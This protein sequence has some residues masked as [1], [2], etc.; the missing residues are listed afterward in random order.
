MGE[1]KFRKQN[2]PTYGK[3]TAMRGLILSL[4]M[5][6]DSDSVQLI[7]DYLDPQD[8][9]SSL[10]YWDRLAWPESNVFRSETY[11]EIEYLKST[12]VLLRPKINFV[13][14]SKLG[15]IV[16]GLQNAALL[17]Y[18]SVS[19]NVW[20]L[21]Q[22]INSVQNKTTIGDEPGT[23]IQLL[24]S[25]PTP[26]QNVPL[27]EILEFKNRR[28]DELLSFRQHFETLVERITLSSDPE[29]DL[30]RTVQEVDEACSDL[31]KT[32]REWQFPVKLTSFQAS[33]NFNI[34]KAIAAASAAYKGLGLTPLAL[35]TTASTVAV[36]GAAAL[37]QIQLKSGLSYKG[38]KR[39]SSP[40]RYAYHVERDLT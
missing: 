17:H 7:Q 30:H 18:E 31:I 33:I 38:I 10:M 39:P 20:S 19:P 35:S 8:L 26:S 37:S 4:P 29:E 40:Y 23:L 28:R 21:S 16:L 15:D 13:G 6:A 3:P 11:N 1:A 24:N 12:G 25:V 14:H 9:R 22:G 5:R 34:T 36:G 32:T 2:D 27:A